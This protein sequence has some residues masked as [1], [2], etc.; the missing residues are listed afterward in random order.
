MD[1]LTAE[2]EILG[3]VE[4]WREAQPLIH[5]ANAQGPGSVWRKRMDLRSPNRDAARVGRVDTRDDLDE[6]RFPRPIFAEQRVDLP[7]VQFKVNI[8]E[9]NGARECL[10]DVAHAHER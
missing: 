9:G 3:D 6:G 5:G 8:V 1:L 10:D 4:L 7:C 2:K